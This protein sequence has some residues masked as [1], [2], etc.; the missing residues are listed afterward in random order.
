MKKATKVLILQFV[1]FAVIFLLARILIVQL[2]VFSGLLIPI[3]SGVLAIVLSPQFKV[4]KIEGKE[5]VFMAWL[6]SKKGK[7]VDWL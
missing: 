3:V 4:L 6:F 1:C 5:K 2:G 7:P